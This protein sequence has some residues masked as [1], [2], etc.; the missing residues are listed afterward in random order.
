MA[1]LSCLHKRLPP[2]SLLCGSRSQTGEGWLFMH[3]CSHRRWEWISTL[4]NQCKTS[5]VEQLSNS[6]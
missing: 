5:E 4:K 2:W 3:V 1:F 6:S